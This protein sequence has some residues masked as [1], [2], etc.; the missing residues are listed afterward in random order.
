MKHTL[1]VRRHVYPHVRF[2]FRRGECLY[3]RA[4]GVGLFGH[5]DG[6][7][8]KNSVPWKRKHR[9]EPLDSTTST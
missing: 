7:C 6:E 9:A 8:M 3:H 4:L 5:S 1:A 2:A